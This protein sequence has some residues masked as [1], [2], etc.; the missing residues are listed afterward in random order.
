MKLEQL[1][2]HTSVRGIV[3]DALVSV[4]S[5]Q[6]FGSE[7]F[8]LAEAHER[9]KG[10][11]IKVGLPDEGK[12]LDNGGA[13]AAAYADAV[14]L[15]LGIALSRLTDI[16]SALCRWEVTKTQ[17][18]NLF[19][20]QAIPMMWDLA[21]TNVLE[22]AAGD[23]TISLGNMA[24]VVD[25]VLATICGAVRQQDAQS[26]SVSAD[27]LVSTDP[28]YYDNI[29]YADLSDFFYVWLRRSLRPVFPD[30]FAALAHL[31]A[32][33]IAPVNLAQA[34]I[35]PGMVVYTRY[36]KVRDAEGKPLSVRAAL[37]LINRTLDD[38]LAEQEGD[39]D[40]DTRWALTWFEQTGFAEGDYGVA[41]QLSKSKNTAV[42]G[43]VEGGILASKAGK[44]RRLK[45][46]ELP[47]NWNPAADKRLTVWEMVLQLIRVLEAE[48]EGAAARLVAKIG[49][50]AEPRANFATAST[51]CANARNARPMPWSTTAWCRAGPRSPGWRVKLRAKWVPAPIICLMKK[52]AP[53]EHDS[54]C[55]GLPGPSGAGGYAAYCFRFA[56]ARRRA[57]GQRPR[58]AG[59]GAIGGGPF[60]RDGTAL[61]PA[62]P[63]A[64]P[65]RRGGNERRNIRAPEDGDQHAGMACSAGGPD[66]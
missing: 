61:D 65:R 42:A 14:G 32:G 29:G 58:P 51:L 15:H 53:H 7:A 6:W 12:P 36:A 54:R 50:Q 56:G 59:G 44:V 35:G 55:A 38:A 25:Q 2:V 30:L 8:E 34:A 1:Q 60:C 37:A 19:R 22:E 43:L 57:G 28:P 9:V 66:V 20:R 18:R 52:E 5:V 64:Y 39:F 33:N 26:Q 4:V 40:A 31:Q 62:G 41:E 47:A 23:Y 27:K 11:A 48:G 21:E 63:A 24:K 3:P 13:G 17:V 46:I 49:S 16:F 45:P 10:D